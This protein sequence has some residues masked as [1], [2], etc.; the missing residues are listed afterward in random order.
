MSGKAKRGQWSSRQSIPVNQ[1]DFESAQLETSINDS[2]TPQSR[3]REGKSKQ[4]WS[5]LYLNFFGS[6]ANLN[7]Y[8]GFLPW[9]IPDKI[10]DRF[11]KS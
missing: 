4:S 2:V 8:L 3:A 9:N 11:F 5:S 6:N 1:T 7:H 10:D